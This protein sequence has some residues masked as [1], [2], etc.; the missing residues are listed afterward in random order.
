MRIEEKA[1]RASKD[2]PLRAKSAMTAFQLKTLVLSTY[3]PNM[4]LRL[5]F[6][7]HSVVVVE[8]M[9]LQLFIDDDNV[10]ETNGIIVTKLLFF[11]VILVFYCFHF[12]LL[13]YCLLEFGGN[14]AD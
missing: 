8:C 13:L 1:L 9:R 14:N 4:L 11:Y 7:V 10:F 5:A 2:S 3:L 12:L 6:L